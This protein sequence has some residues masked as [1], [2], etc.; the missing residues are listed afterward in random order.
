M[1]AQ[2]AQAKPKAAK[3]VPGLASPPPAKPQPQPVATGDDPANIPPHPSQLNSR[4]PAP[5]PSAFDPARSTPI[6]AEST[7]TKRV[8]A[9]PDGSRTMQVST[10]PKWFKDAS[11]AVKE[12]DLGVVSR[13]NGTKEAKAAPGAAK[14][15]K[16][17][18]AAVA[19][20]ETSAGTVELRHPGAVAAAGVEAGKTVR[21]A[22]ALPGGRD[23]V[24]GLTP[25]GFEES[26][27]LADASGPPS[28]L[29]QL[30]LPAGLSARQASSS[31]VELVDAAGSVVGAFGG[32]IAFDASFPAA[33]PAAT[34]AVNVRLVADP[35]APGTASHAGSV[36]TIEVSIS[37]EWLSAPARKF[38]VTIDPTFFGKW[39]LAADGGRDTFIQNAE[40]ANSSF[41]TSPYLYVGTA[42]G[43]VHVN[44][45]LLYFDLG[46]T[47]APN[48]Y[49][50]ESHVWAYNFYSPS[51]AQPRQVNLAGLGSAF[52]NTTT[53]NTQ[54]AL[55][56]VGIIPGPTFAKGVGLLRGLDRLQHHLAGPALAGGGPEPRPRAAGRQ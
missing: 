46:T 2:P 33:G 23:L 30:V 25:D 18:G 55:D 47:P 38:P 52:S 7:A 56:A 11:G 45:A 34:T 21:Y 49:V 12:I 28:Y 26:V 17:T 50:V 24:L 42:D 40:Y 6:D 9:N 27:I 13:A 41:G 1:P 19:T 39:S 29:S 48:R 54:P 31:M 44:R 51:C 14:L 3:D 53:W 43:G 8:W 15:A 20:V 16:S 35:A 4:R 32:G 37:A 36:A 5:K 10:G 22:K